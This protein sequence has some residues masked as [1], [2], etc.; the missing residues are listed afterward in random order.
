MMRLGD[1]G[2][3]GFECQI[4]GNKNGQ[5][6]DIDHQMIIRITFCI[7][8]KVYDQLIVRCRFYH[9]LPVFKCFYVDCFG[10][11]RVFRR[12]W[13]H[14][15]PFSTQRLEPFPWT[16]CTAQ[17]S[18]VWQQSAPTNKIREETAA[19]ERLIFNCSQLILIDLK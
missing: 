5:K 2:H 7:F 13:F 11:L 9:S 18:S 3:L 4:S 6:N 14:H 12:G 15:R 1:L 10:V 19:F 17:R 16:G 8:M